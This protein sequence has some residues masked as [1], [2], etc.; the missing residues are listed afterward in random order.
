MP[1]ISFTMRKFAIKVRS[2]TPK[3]VDLINQRYIFA[4]HLLNG[5]SVPKIKY[6]FIIIIYFYIDYRSRAYKCIY[7]RC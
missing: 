5:D 2:N 7:H 1:F 3:C 4:W 6:Y